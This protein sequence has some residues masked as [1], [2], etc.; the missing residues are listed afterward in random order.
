MK[1]YKIDG[2]DY[3]IIITYPFEDEEEGKD[4]KKKR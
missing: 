4:A 3:P 2:K 1:A